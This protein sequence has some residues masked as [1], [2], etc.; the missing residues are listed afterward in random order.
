MWIR[1]RLDIGWTDIAWACSRCLFPTA[2]DESA[3]PRLEAAWAGE[4]DAVAC[5]SVRTGFDLL[6]RALALPPASEVLMSALNVPGMFRIVEAHDL[7][8]VP[9]DLGPS[10]SPSPELVRDAI[11]PRS[12]AIVVAHLFG[13]RADL[14]PIRALA[15]EHG[16]L[17]IE[18]RAQ[19]FDG[20][21][22]S[23]PDGNDAALYSFGTIKT[24]T[25]FGGAMLTVRD[26]ALA[27]RIRSLERTLPPQTR[28]AYLT[29][30]LKYAG[31]KVLT[32]QRTYAALRKAFDWA[33][34]DVDAWLQRVAAGFPA[35][36]LLN[37]IRHRPSTPNVAL[38]ER[39]IQRFDPARANHQRQRGF[40]LAA[41]L[42]HDLPVAGDPDTHTFDLFPLR[43]GNPAAVQASLHKAGF[44]AIM[45]GSMT[46][47]PCSKENPTTTSNAERLLDEI[48]F[49]PLYPAMPDEEL[50]RMA[51]MVRESGEP[52]AEGEQNP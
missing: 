11:T 16:L 43:L 52:S 49:L 24:A 30:L 17:L 23:L 47:A 28:W 18:D 22:V 45:R 41:S 15:Q 25:A 14:T 38:M 31:A 32:G 19:A 12:R 33:G 39:R 6:L 42:G 5:L 8:P 44:D 21:P 51:S 29:R 4:S 34:R 2:A 26:Q 46:T 50:S 13:A 10:L 9:L 40:R 27:E 7:V 48:L 3:R 36:Q 1:R 20:L 35:E 37:A